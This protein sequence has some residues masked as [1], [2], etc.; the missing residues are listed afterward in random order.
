MKA[1]KRINRSKIRRPISDYDAVETSGMIDSSKPLKFED[2]G[3]RLPDVPPTQV[4]SIRLPSALLN[5]LKAISSE[6]DIPYQSLIKL[7]LSKSVSK[8]KKTSVA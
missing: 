4:V 1:K 3:L 5:E 8:F 6:K 7:M 2:L